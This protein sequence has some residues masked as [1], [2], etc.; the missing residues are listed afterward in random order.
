MA[1]LGRYRTDEEKRLLE[2]RARV[3]KPVAP[4]LVADNPFLFTTRPLLGEML[5]RTELFRAVA[6][7]SGAIVECGVA[8][9]N[10]LM[11]YAWLSTLLEPYAINRRII[12]FDTFEGFRHITTQD[13][14]DVGE[15]TFAS[16]QRTLLEQAIELYDASRPLGHMPRVELV[17]G[18]ATATIP[19]YAQRHPELTVALLYLD[20]DLY[21]P[22]RVALEHLAPL[23]T[24]GGIIAFDEFNYER[25]AGETQAFKELF[26]VRTTRLRRLSYEPFLAYFIVGE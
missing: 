22:T 6:G 20:F 23:V 18:D 24:R 9:G 13:P 10:S 8:Q 5:A 2:Q 15:D 12:G 16:N 17:R 21:L 7:V 11:L 1:Q 3:L 14:G 19:E 4:Q 25:F 26:D